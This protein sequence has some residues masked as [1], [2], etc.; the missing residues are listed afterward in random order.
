MFNECPEL[1]SLDLSNFDSSNV[2]N[3]SF[4]FNNCIKLKEIKGLNNFNTSNV[5]Y[6]YDKHV[7]KL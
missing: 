7:S 6:I 5:I 2:T 4:M 1:I 3:I